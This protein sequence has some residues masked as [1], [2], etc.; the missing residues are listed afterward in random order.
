MVD[1]FEKI[2]QRNPH[3]S[4]YIGEFYKKNHAK[5][6]FHDQLSEEMVTLRHPNIIYPVGDPIFIHVFNLEQLGRGYQTI[7]PILTPE[8]DTKRKKVMNLVLQNAPN[9][10]AYTDRGEFVAT[11]DRLIDK[12][13]QK[14]KS[15]KL[16]GSLGSKKV[17][18]TDEELAVI[19]YHIKR[20][21]VDNGI[22]EPLLRDPYIE[23][24]HSVGLKRISIVHKV[25]GMLPTN[26]R[27]VD[28]IELEF[29]L[30]RLSEKIG[31]PVSDSQPIIDAAL[32]DGSRINIVYSSDVSRE[33]PSFTIRKFSEKPPTMPQLVKWGTFSSQIAAYLWLCLEYGM[34][35]FVCGETASGKTTSLN[36]M[37]SFIDFK[38][39]IYTAEDT[40]EVI[41]PQ[42]VW[43]RLITRESGPKD[44][45][46][47]LFDLVRTA[48]RSRPDYVVVG[49][50]RGKEGSV[51]FQ[52]IQTGHAVL[53]TFHASSIQKMIQRF[54]GHP[55]NVPIRFM[56]NLNVAL[57]QEIVYK[58]GRILRRCSS[59]E[60]ILKYSKEKDGVL[61]RA[62]FRWDPLTDTHHFR[63]MY[64]SFILENKVA[65]KMGLEDRHDI[66]NELAR[67]TEIIAAMV[68]DNLLDYDGVN[69]VFS[70]YYEKG[71]AGLPSKYKPSS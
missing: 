38:K 31:K 4:R 10:P 16:L 1:I 49:E 8:W 11:I 35:I 7:E 59:V 48:L 43:Q 9:E 60:E 12:V 47:E 63:G 24:I 25:F 6:I 21:I 42:P 32:P 30:R 15:G 67:R 57:F 65:P 3:L 5:P 58:D 37:L 56:D 19:T 17:P 23:D 62:V 41:V 39:K 40:P 68:D 20:D 51:A 18:L 33:G 46:V 71:I 55:I 29:Y 45:R 52:A 44:G 34:S 26:L 27:F 13:S 36:S 54:T 2:Q 70:T 28:D 69:A 14:T 64:N 66:Y 61:T 53:C 22:L 50:V